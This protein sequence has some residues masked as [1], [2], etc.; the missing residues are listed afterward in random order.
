MSL[1]Q[2]FAYHLF[3]EG[4]GVYEKWGKATYTQYKFGRQT[5]YY[6]RSVESRCLNRATE[7]FDVLR[8]SKRGHRCF[9]IGNGPSL[10]K[11][12]LTLLKGE[13]TIGSNYIFMNYDKMGF[14]PTY[15]CIVNFL[16]AQQRAGDINAI[17]GTTK[18]FPFFLRYCM[19][20]SPDTLFLNA[21]PDFEFST[22][23]TQWISWRSTVT[24]FAMQIAYYLGFDKVYLIG[25]DH[26]YEQPDQ[27]KE[28]AFIESAK[29]DPNHFHPDYFGK[30]IKWQKAD[31][32]VME[33]VYALARN[34]FERDG[35]TIYNATVG[36]CL[37]LFER[38]AYEDLF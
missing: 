15:L 5:K 6:R 21:N 30:G 28:G 16:V 23:I 31:T 25:V 27:G 17:N 19:N 38:V 7:Y 2:T 34:G 3:G 36:G 14:L 37:E 8:N 9:I 33:R 12:D 29:A 26:S 18:I 1:T 20:E 10:N 32:D 22:D 35:R 24:F 11:M 4:N 13:F